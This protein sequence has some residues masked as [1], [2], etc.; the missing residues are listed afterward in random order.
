MV[1]PLEEAKPLIPTLI[2][3]ASPIAQLIDDHRHHKFVS[4]MVTKSVHKKI[5]RKGIAPSSWWLTCQQ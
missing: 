5:R 3:P 1:V 4:I 2:L